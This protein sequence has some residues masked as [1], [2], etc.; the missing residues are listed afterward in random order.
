MELLPCL[1]LALF[2][3]SLSPAPMVSQDIFPHSFLPKKHAIIPL[4]EA[5][6]EVGKEQGPNLTGC[7]G[8]EGESGL[9]GVEVGAHGE[10]VRFLD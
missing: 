4:E 9:G 6:N 3:E 5:G 1:S 10:T 2:P 7:H 8:L